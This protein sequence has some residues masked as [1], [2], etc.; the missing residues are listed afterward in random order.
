MYFLTISRNKLVLWYLNIYHVPVSS[1]CVCDATE[2]TLGGV[3]GYPLFRFSQVQLLSR[4]RTALYFLSISLNTLALSCLYTH[5]V[6]ISS[7]CACDVADERLGVVR[8]YP[9]L[10]FPLKHSHRGVSC[11][12]S[13]DCSSLPSLSP[14]LVLRSQI[15]YFWLSR[16]FGT[17][18]LMLCCI[19]GSNESACMLLTVLSASFAVI[20]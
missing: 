15:V 18:I 6:S 4:G 16:S 8:G 10:L 13:A 5:H 20:L 7:L 19:C 11:L 3:C 12:P 1:L 2:N 14:C 17:N 9:V